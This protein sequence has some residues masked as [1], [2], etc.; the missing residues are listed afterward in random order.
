M[1][2]NT[3]SHRWL[4]YAIHNKRTPFRRYVAAY[5]PAGHAHMHSAKRCFDRFRMYACVLVTARSLFTAI[6]R[7]FSFTLART[8]HIHIKLI[9]M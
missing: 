2:F 1:Y 9:Y 4:L 7:L 6:P 8:V 3:W 5:T